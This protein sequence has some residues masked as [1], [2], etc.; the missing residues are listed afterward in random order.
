MVLVFK[1]GKLRQD[2]MIVV[3]ATRHVVY[4]TECHAENRYRFLRHPEKFGGRDFILILSVIL[5]VLLVGMTI[6]QWLPS[7]PKGVFVLLRWH[8]AE[9]VF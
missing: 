9:S 4:Y 6:Y 8:K 2:I 5:E 3:V 1:T 7:A